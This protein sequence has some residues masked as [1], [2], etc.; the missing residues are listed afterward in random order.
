LIGLARKGIA[1][2]EMHER[3]IKNPLGEFHSPAN[4]MRDYVY[5]LEKL[6]IDTSNT[7]VESVPAHI[8]NPSGGGASF[9]RVNK[10]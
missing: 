4:W 7:S 5:I 1:L 8:W 2:I 9:I 10:C 6:N 3:G